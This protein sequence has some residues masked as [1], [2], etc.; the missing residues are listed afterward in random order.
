MKA[1]LVISLLIMSL[2]SVANEITQYKY[3][4]TD[5]IVPN[6]RE[7]HYAVYIINKEPCIFVK[8][9]REDEVEEYCKLDDS[10][11]DL[12]INSPTIYPIDLRLSSKTLY[13]TVAA[14]WNEQK[15]EIFFPRKS[16]TCESTGR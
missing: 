9:F 11:L 2:T 16:I 12:K 3:Y 8:D 10:E 4:Q 1:V 15:C 7:P 5:N 14:P 6:G 13:F